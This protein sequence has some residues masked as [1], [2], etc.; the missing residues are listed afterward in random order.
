MIQDTMQFLESLSKEQLL[1]L[2]NFLTMYYRDREVTVNLQS[3]PAPAPFTFIPAPVNPP[4]VPPVIGPMWNGGTS[5]P[6]PESSKT[7]CVG[8][9]SMVDLE[10]LNH[11]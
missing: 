8:Y 6:L 4:Y 9:A 10:H 1:G 7:T 3:A 2:I 5:D 11:A